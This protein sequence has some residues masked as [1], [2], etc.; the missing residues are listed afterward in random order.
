MKDIQRLIG[1]VMRKQS[2]VNSFK[3]A[4]VALPLLASCG[5]NVGTAQVLVDPN[6]LMLP[7][8]QDGQ[9]IGVNPDKS[10]TC[11]SAL[12][13]MLAPPT[14]T[15]GQ[16]LT[17]M[18]NN[19]TGQNELSCVNT[20]SGLNDVTTQTRINKAMT[21]IADLQNKVTQIT[22]GGG[23]RSR[24]V[25]FTAGTTNGDIL[26]PNSS[27]GSR[28]G[29]LLCAAEYG[30]NA[31]ICTPFEIYE[32]VVVGDVLN[33]NAD[34]GP[35]MVYM[36]AW[37]PPFAAGGSEPNAGISENCGG[38]TYDTADRRW[39]NAH[40]TFAVPTGGTVRVP[41]FN[42]SVSCNTAVRLACCK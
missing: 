8:C 25:G 12:T 30:V 23:L 28:A 18:K 4:L 26:G 9:L 2:I 11:V 34:V 5:G 14:C 41:R 37:I 27:R 10:L 1:G 42:A 29:N 19:A 20:G 33:G 17:S 38:F 31:H 36:E 13:G 21:D 7:D 3:T 16:V 24:Y 6:G 39:R 40:F 35:L 15:A 22:T 32:S